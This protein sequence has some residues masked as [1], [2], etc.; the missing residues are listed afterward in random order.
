MLTKIHH[1]GIA[2]RSIDETLGLY[3]EGLGLPVTKDAVLEEQGIRGVLL[4]TGEVELELLEPLRPDSA[5][6]R[7][8]ESRGEGL[9]HLCFGT[10]DIDSDLEAAKAKGLPLID[11]QPRPGLAGRI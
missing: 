11:E 2:V 5:V 6:G 8:L 3:R 9:H 7:F 10:D 4:S 1:I